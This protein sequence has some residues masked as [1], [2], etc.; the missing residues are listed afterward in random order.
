[1]KKGKAA[2]N[3]EAIH[4]SVSGSGSD[5]ARLLLLTLQGSRE[6]RVSTRA[7][8]IAAGTKL[9]DLLHLAIKSGLSCSLN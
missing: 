9:P 8:R 3:T 4:A 1:M 7:R 5:C 2:A 6:A